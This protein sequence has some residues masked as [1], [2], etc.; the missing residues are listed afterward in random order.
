MEP[1]RA[2]EAGYS[3]MK[4][5]TLADA[6]DEFLGRIDY[7]LYTRGKRLGDLLALRRDIENFQKIGHAILNEPV[8]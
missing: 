5:R 1:G 2:F 7:V 3:A 8:E 6:C 4:Q